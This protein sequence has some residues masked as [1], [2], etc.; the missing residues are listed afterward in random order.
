MSW[1]IVGKGPPAG[2]AWEFARPRELA[3]CCWCGEAILPGDYAMLTRRGPRIWW[4]HYDES[5][6]YGKAPRVP[7]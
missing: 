3:Q 6:C 2:S 5:P 1:E 4:S 7:A